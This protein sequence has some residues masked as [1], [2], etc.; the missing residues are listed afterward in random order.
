M[1]DD[2]SLKDLS[3]FSVGF[4]GDGSEGERGHFGLVLCDFLFEIFDLIQVAV[5]VADFAFERLAMFF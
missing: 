3:G 2:F 4:S 1:V 5:E